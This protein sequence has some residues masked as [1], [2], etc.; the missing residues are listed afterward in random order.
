LVSAVNPSRFVESHLCV[1]ELSP[2]SNLH[3]RQQ[4]G[5]SKIWTNVNVLVL[6]FGNKIWKRNLQKLQ[7]RCIANLGLRMDTR[8]SALWGTSMNNCV[9]LTW[10]KPEHWKNWISDNVWGRD[11]EIKKLPVASR[12]LCCGPNS[13]IEAGKRCTW[14]L[15]QTSALGWTKDGTRTRLR[16]GW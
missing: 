9:Q 12:S 1:N 14:T 15:V 5:D 6:V 2:C 4:R 16:A 7:G 10:M 11:Y 8:K 13:G 3:A